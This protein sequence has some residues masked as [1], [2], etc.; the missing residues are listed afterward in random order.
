M[1]GTYGLKRAKDRARVLDLVHRS[2]VGSSLN[3]EFNSLFS[4]AATVTG[5]P[6]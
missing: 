3:T 6:L 2:G 4:N 5:N 1:Y